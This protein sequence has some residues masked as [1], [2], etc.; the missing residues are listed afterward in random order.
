MGN[1]REL[2]TL[3]Q[4]SD[5]HFGDKLGGHGVESAK[6]GPMITGR[7]RSSLLKAPASHG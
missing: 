5:L 7:L 1:D 3:L 2:L 6:P 4:I